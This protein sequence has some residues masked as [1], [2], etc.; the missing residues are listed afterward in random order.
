MTVAQWDAKSWEVDKKPAKNPLGEVPV[1][2]FI[3]RRER[4]P[5]GMGEFEDVTDIMDR[6]NV[7]ALD[8]LVIQTMQSYRQRWG[9]GINVEDADGDP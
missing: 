8:R 1:I 2:P 6:I 9:K 7:T 4:A 5:M 3:N